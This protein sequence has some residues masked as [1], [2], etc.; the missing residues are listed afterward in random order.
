MAVAAMGV[1]AMG[2]LALRRGNG[3]SGVPGVSDTEAEEGLWRGGYANRAG[4]ETS[5]FPK[6]E[7]A[8]PLPDSPATSESPSRK[9]E[10]VSS[11][12]ATSV[13][14]GD[15]PGTN[16]L[17]SPDSSFVLRPVL[18]SSSPRLVI[19]GRVT[20]ESGGPAAGARVGLMRHEETDQGSRET[21]AARDRTDPDGSFRFEVADGPH[22][23]FNVAEDGFVG[24]SKLIRADTPSEAITEAPGGRRVRLDIVL[25]R[26]VR[27][28]GFVRD[29]TGAGIG[30]A[31]VTGEWRGS[32]EGSRTAPRGASQFTERWIMVSTDGEGRFT[33]DSLPGGTVALT[34]MAEGYPPEETTVESPSADDVVLVL[35]HP[36]GSISGHVYLKS[37]GEAVA[38]ASVSLRSSHG[39]STRHLRSP[40]GSTF[41]VSTVPGEIDTNGAGEFKISGLKEGEYVLNAV[42]DTLGLFPSS[43]TGGEHRIVLKG[44]EAR[45]GVDLFLYPGHTIHGLVIDS[46][47]RKPIEGAEIARFRFYAEVEAPLVSDGAGRFVCAGAMIPRFGLVVTKPGYQRWS[48]TVNLPLDSTDVHQTIELIP[49]MEISGTVRDEANRPVAGA[50][51]EAMTPNAWRGTPVNTDGEGKYVAP[52]QPFTT[53]RIHVRAAGYAE[54]YTDFMKVLDTSLAGVDIVLPRTATVEGVVVDEEGHGIAGADVVAHQ[55]VKMNQNGTVTTSV[56]Q[57]VPSDTE[58]RFSIAGLPVKG[59]SLTAGYQGTVT[60]PLAVE[61]SSG[62]TRT[63][64]RLVIRDTEKKRFV[65]G[66]VTDNEG[67]ALAEVTINV[68]VERGTTSFGHSGGTDA[69]GRYRVEFKGGESASM[70]V[71]ARGYRPLRV[72][73]PDLDRDDLDFTLEPAGLFRVVGSV[74]DSETREPI[75]VFSVFGF[76]GDKPTVDPSQ[77]GIFVAENLTRTDSHQFN[78]RAEGYLPG[79]ATA[80]APAGD[81]DTSEITIAL[82]R[83]GAVMGR[84]VGGTPSTPLP[85]VRVAAAMG[86]LT[87]GVDPYTHPIQATRTDADGRFAMAGL[88]AGPTIILVHAPESFVDGLREVKVEHGKETDLGEIVL[89]GGSRVR[90]RLVRNPGGLGVEGTGIELTGMAASPAVSK[91]TRT[92]SQGGFEF[93]RLQP[94]EYTL[95]VAQWALSADPIRV[96]DGATVEAAL[97]LGSGRIVGHVT[98]GGVPAFG[99]VT[100]RSAAVSQSRQTQTDRDGNFVALDLLPGVWEMNVSASGGADGGGRESISETV[101]IAEGETVEKTLSFGNRRLVGVALASDGRPLVGAKVTAYRVQDGLEGG[102]NQGSVQ[103]S[104]EGTFIFSQLPAGTY[105]VAVD[106]LNG[107][108][109]S[110]ENVV[111]PEEGDS[112]EVILQ[113]SP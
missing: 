6:T 26:G 103:T 52:A 111:V 110:V 86:S 95:R 21:L 44:E 1:I 65:G 50:S 33:L 46:L 97:Q 32:G 8:S 66:R 94:G 15:R 112:A 22:F 84:V 10:A 20:V 81:V 61:L 91:E 11:D 72:S 68:M 57:P 99:R 107:V 51:V 49:A 101:T 36:R 38:G 60:E 64:V 83:G 88:P 87:Y 102:T 19:D 113:L 16:S 56:G 98:R 108:V 89:T 67:N 41:T 69:D 9:G 55:T 76:G 100:L 28:R 27:I 47:S 4:E 40:D 37:T 79:L 80:F 34:A 13:S 109:V 48:N 70:T 90:G 53:L 96:A 71:S 45:T 73:L 104:P 30:T 23:V 93:D 105:R 12:S 7:A 74:V 54:T 106:G 14:L 85:D 82:G 43:D 5:P 62:E 75:P 3:G 78:V 59:L 39:D 31:R 77:P 35:R 17:D 58:G 24:T 42:K 18:D 63:G 29:E 2:W 25:A 92:D